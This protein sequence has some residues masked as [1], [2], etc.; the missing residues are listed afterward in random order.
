MHFQYT[1][2][3]KDIYRKDVG[4][5]HGV[6]DR[7]QTYLVGTRDGV[8]ASSTVVRMRDDEAYDKTLAREFTVKSYDYIDNGV[9][10]PPS[11]V[12]ARTHLAARNPDSAP[13][14][15]AY[16]EYVPRRM[17]IRF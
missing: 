7:C 5:F 13:V 12:M 8:Y 9:K 16:G 2:S 11:I 17:A 3:N 4:I 14:V 15:P 10:P 1:Q 6:N